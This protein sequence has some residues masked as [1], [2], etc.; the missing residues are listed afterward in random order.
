MKLNYS[1]VGFEELDRKLREFGPKVTANALRAA[2]YAGTKVILDAI[3]IS[4]IDSD[5]RSSPGQP[6]H[7]DSGLLKASLITPRKRTPKNIAHHR[8][9]VRGGKKAKFTRIARSRN[10]AKNV[11]KKRVG[12][13]HSLAGPN[14]YGAFLEF[15]TSKMAARPFMR[16]AFDNNTYFAVEAIRARL[17][18]AVELAAKAK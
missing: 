13:Y 5:T 1:I 11:A 16:P 18:K 7:S 15:G 4:I 17:A 2:N 12:K 6:P 9:V 3:K 8:I 10:T 14:V